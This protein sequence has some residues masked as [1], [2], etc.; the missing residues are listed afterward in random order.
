LSGRL[1]CRI[2]CRFFH[3]IEAAA[4]HL[5]ATSHATFDPYQG[6]LVTEAFFP[7]IAT[8][9]AGGLA[10]IADDAAAA[11]GIATFGHDRRSGML[12][13]IEKLATSAM[14][15]AIAIMNGRSVGGAT[16]SSLAYEVRTVE[17]RESATGA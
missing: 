15:L 8:L 4:H 17:A 1:R 11:T 6:L 2:V 13:S 7:C 10:I 9:P 5:A 16:R 12:C 14:S 3:I